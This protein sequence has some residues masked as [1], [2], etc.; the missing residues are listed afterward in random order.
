QRRRSGGACLTGAIQQVGE[1]RPVAKRGKFTAGFAPDARVAVG[2]SL[3]NPFAQLRGG[4]RAVFPAVAADHEVTFLRRGRWLGRRSGGS[5]F[6]ARGRGVFLCTRL[7][8]C[9][10]SPLS[11]TRGLRRNLGR[12]V[13]GRRRGSFAGGGSSNFTSS[14]RFTVGGV[15]LV[16]EFLELGEL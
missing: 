3:G 10:L 5:F 14:S 1:L 9:L 4:H 2:A 13:D 11:A 15:D 6:F 16:E 7:G 12:D 8:V